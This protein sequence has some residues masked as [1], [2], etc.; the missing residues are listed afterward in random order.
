MSWTRCHVMGELPGSVWSGDR[1]RNGDERHRAA[2][3]LHARIHASGTGADR[4]CAASRWLGRVCHGQ[5]EFSRP[6]MRRRFRRVVRP[7]ISC[8]VASRPLR[9]DRPLPTPFTLTAIS[10]CQPTHEA[11][12][13]YRDADRERPRAST[14][15]SGA[16]ASAGRRHSRHVHVFARRRAAASRC[17]YDFVSFLIAWPWRVRPHRL[18]TS[19][20]ADHP[21]APASAA[22]PHQP[23]HPHPCA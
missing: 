10:G 2:A 12:R 7:G 4:R 14:P 3:H 1:R 21:R 6:S 5:R 22:L 11:Q 17:T 18:M 16:M 19:P 9:S 20:L 23:S 8:R 13:I 15:T